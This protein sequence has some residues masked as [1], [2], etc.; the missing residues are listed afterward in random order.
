MTG[1]TPNCYAQEVNRGAGQNQ[2]FGLVVVLL[3]GCGDVAQPSDAGTGGQAELEASGG[4]SSAESGGGGAPSG[5]GGSSAGGAQ[6]SD[7]AGG[8]AQT[9]GVGADSGGSHSGGAGSAGAGGA[10]EATSVF[11]PSVTTPKIMIVGDSISAGPGCYKGYL[12]EQLKA[13]GFS[14]Y[15]FVGEYSD[16]CGSSLKH[17]AVSC[18]TSADFTKEMFSVSSCSARVYDGMSPLVA[19]HQPDLVM[20]QLGV[21][22]V[23]GGSAAV[24]G[25]LDN[26][27]TLLAQARA[28]NPQLVFVV[29]QIHKIIT[30]DCTNNQSTTNAEAL[31]EAVPAWAA[32]ETTQQSPVFVADLWT[33]SDPHE[34]EDCVHPNDAGAK[35][36]GENWYNA[37]KS[38]LPK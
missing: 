6:L 35:R 36:M 31:V 23:W 17:S 30:D 29:A 26:Y 24:S 10:G 19:R 18:T 5:S 14:K 32:S 27:S 9:G 25:I 21:N 37:L 33:N 2:W 3:L 13:G 22:D 28:K 4:S 38:I 11:P 8:E 15:E 1:H 34:A 12:D 7:G 16:D 20:I